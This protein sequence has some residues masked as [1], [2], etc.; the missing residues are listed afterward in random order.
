MGRTGSIRVQGQAQAEGARSF[1]STPSGLDGCDAQDS[2]L[3]GLALNPSCNTPA[4]AVCTF[5]EVSSAPAAVCSDAMD[6]G[7]AQA[8]GARSLCSPGV[9]S[10]GVTV[11]SVDP[12]VPVINLSVGLRSTER[13]AAAKC[14]TAL[15]AGGRGARHIH[16]S[17]SCQDHP[18]G[19]WSTA[20]GNGA[21]CAKAARSAA[22]SG[23]RAE[24]FW[25]QK[26]TD[27]V[28]VGRTFSRAIWGRSVS[29]LILSRD[30]VR[31]MNVSR[32]RSGHVSQSV[33]GEDES[34]V[35]RGAQRPAGV[36]GLRPGHA[37][38]HAVPIFEHEVGGQQKALEL[39]FEGGAEVLLSPQR[40][41]GFHEPGLQV[42]DGAP[43]LRRSVG[44]ELCL[45]LS[46]DGHVGDPGRHL[47]VIGDG[48]WRGLNQLAAL[49]AEQVG[50]LEREESVRCT[51]VDDAIEVDGGTPLGL[52]DHL[53]NRYVARPVSEALSSHQIAKLA[54]RDVRRWDAEERDPRV[55]EPELV[56]QLSFGVTYG[57]QLAPANSDAL[58]TMVVDLR[59]EREGVVDTMLGVNLRDGAGGYG[60]EINHASSLAP[61][62]A[63]SKVLAPDGRP[64]I[65]Q[66]VAAFC[67]GH[68][69]ETPKRAR[70]F[71]YSSVP[72]KPSALSCLRSSRYPSW[73]RS[74]DARSSGSIAPF[75]DAPLL[76]SSLA[77]PRIVGPAS[78]PSNILAS[79]RIFERD[80]VFVSMSTMDRMS[81]NPTSCLG[82]PQ[83]ASIGTA[84]IGVPYL[85][86]PGQVSLVKCP[87]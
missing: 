77:M 67:G 30:S 68:A 85:I 50:G 36:V 79:R 66:E 56:E 60:E 1:P 20:D 84:P 34:A 52:H 40:T 16:S 35:Q 3:A 83:L 51:R 42:E 54:G 70:S 61:A 37:L 17:H 44:G 18:A 81:S 38:G 26:T 8:E 39:D 65:Q 62:S 87:R 33:S 73:M 58:A 22:A 63:L 19:L 48:G 2:N 76:F 14:A 55:Q 78:A 28:K 15:N 11:P 69:E 64:T 9:V 21:P 41:T 86:G 57:D 43:G 25:G 6:S 45:N 46:A 7:Q 53:Q 23:P 82:E 12:I 49:Q 74:S 5:S 71:S 13:S 29:E 47:R 80:R 10:M 75:G 31:Q 32:H 24:G 27:F 4:A 72:S 59:R